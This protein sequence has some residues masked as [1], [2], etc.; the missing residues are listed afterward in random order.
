MTF[1]TWIRVAMCSSSTAVAAGGKPGDCAQPAVYMHVKQVGPRALLEI[2]KQGETQGVTTLPV[3]L[4]LVVARQRPMGIP[5]GKPANGNPLNLVNPR[6][7]EGAGTHNLHRMATRL[8]L[9]AKVRHHGFGPPPL[10]GDKPAENVNNSGHDNAS[11]QR[12][13]KKHSDRR[14]GW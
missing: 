8:L 12:V 3:E 11:N 2:P 9:V 5:I 1:W 14:E 4:P 10:L 13:E 7:G 6:L